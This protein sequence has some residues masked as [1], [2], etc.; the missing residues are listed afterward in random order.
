MRLW[1]T[2]ALISCGR[3][4]PQPEPTEPKPY[5]IEHRETCGDLTAIWRGTHDGF[6][7]YS[8][9]SFQRGK[10]PPQKAPIEIGP[11]TSFQ[12]FPP[13]CKH[14]LLHASHQG[15]YHIVTT[16]RL[17]AYLRGG[18]PDHILAGEPDPKGISGAGAIHDGMWTA[19]DEVRYE[20]GCCDPPMVSHFVIP[21]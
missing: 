17:D 2:L 21:K 4:Q 7:L 12:I 16:A 5:P 14:V 9:L 13:D 3:E 10:A 1:L 11:D 19:N 20:W 8:E 6:D 15:P 18:A